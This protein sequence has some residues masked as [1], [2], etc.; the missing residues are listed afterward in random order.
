MSTQTLQFK[1]DIKLILDAKNIGQSS[2]RTYIS[3]LL[4]VASR[5]GIKIK[6]VKHFT[7]KAVEIL[8][9]LMQLPYNKRKSVLTALSHVAPDVIIY[10]EQ[11]KKDYDEHNNKS[12]EQLLTPIESQNW[13][14]WVQVLDIY[15][16]REA[17]VNSLFKTYYSPEAVAY[18]KNFNNPLNYTM[19]DEDDR[20]FI[21][22]FHILMMYV[23]IPPRRAEDIA[24]LKIRD[25]NKDVD[26][27]VDFKN[28]LIVFNQYKTARTYNKQEFVLPKL[29]KT[30]LLRYSKKFNVTNDYIGSLGLSFNTSS[31]TITQALNRVFKPKKVSV[32]ILRHSYITWFHRQDGNA[33]NILLMEELARKMGHSLQMQLQYIR[34]DAPVVEA[35]NVENLENND[36]DAM[37]VE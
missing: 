27:Y 24:K 19:F 8:E 10:N 23:L 21:L 1:A 9:S 26:N 3:T 30:Y 29:M 32:N 22:D 13:V 36:D 31:T 2:Q 37:D 4:N 5:T 35:A 25:Y 7:D 12:K 17:R 33:S 16:K 34:L 20:Q 6:K 18:A 14:P 15:K 11:K 28:N